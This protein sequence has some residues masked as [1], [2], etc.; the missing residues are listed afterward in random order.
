MQITAVSILAILATLSAAIASDA[1]HGLHARADCGNIVPACNGGSIHGQTDC[2]CR[3]QQERCD[4]WSC[5]GVS[6]GAMVCGQA[7][8]GCVFI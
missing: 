4:L 6:T 7:G 8:T 3:G 2:R 5:P 1:H